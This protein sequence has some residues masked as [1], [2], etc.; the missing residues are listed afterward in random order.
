[1]VVAGVALSTLYVTR[2]TAQSNASPIFVSGTVRPQE[3]DAEVVPIVASFNK[4]S[5]S[6]S[7]AQSVVLKTPG[8]IH[9]FLISSD[10]SARKTRSAEAGISTWPRIDLSRRSAA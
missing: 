9:Q 2:P 1:M 6:R 7:P 3:G 4:S 8:R 5:A 10:V